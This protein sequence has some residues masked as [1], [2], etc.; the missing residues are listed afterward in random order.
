[1]NS[2]IVSPTLAGKEGVAASIVEPIGRYRWRICALLFFATTIN[3]ID[4]QVLGVLAPEL[5][6]SIGWNEIQYS[7]IVTAFQA[8]Y[9][10]GLLVAG[11][12]IDR[13]GTRVGY[14]ISVSIWSLAAMAHALVRTPLGFGGARFLLGLGEAGNFP[15]S[16]KAAA[17]WFPRRERAFAVGLVNAGT[18]VGAI[19]APLTVPWIFL[20]FGWQAAFLITGLLGL[21]WLFFWWTTYRPPHQHSKVS[22]EELAYITRDQSGPAVRIPWLQL[23][24]YRQTW[25]Y[26][27]GKFMLDPIWWF[28]LFWLPKFLNTEHG[29]SLGQL[30]L[31]LVVIYVVSDVGSIAGGY[32]SSALI[33]RG[34]SVNTARKV[35]MVICAL[36]IVPVFFGASAKSLWAAVTLISLATAGHQ[37][38]MT[39]LFTF[40]SDVFPPYAVGSVVG[41]GG[42]AGAIGGTL[43]APFTGFLLQATGSYVPIFLIASLVYLIALLII[44]LLVPHYQA[45]EL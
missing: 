29:L 24:G 15:A 35:A 32:V 21:P 31:P 42:F 6:K 13:I 14:F 34:H 22:R 44:H 28:F 41:I 33:K 20:H 23:V 4:R 37:G 45:A 27:I 38:F 36:M 9:A 12:W 3:Y 2:E 8:A 5:Q 18:N 17:E 39:N 25:A 16:L 11:G 30:G 26:I 19:L 43:F 7:Y 40:P 1:V 10:I